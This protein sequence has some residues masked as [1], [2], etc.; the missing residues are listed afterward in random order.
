MMDEKP[1]RGPQR[2][3]GSKTETLA[4]R[5]AVG[6][7]RASELAP[8]ALKTA[9]AKRGFAE[10][11][12]LMEWRDVV[13]EA[14]ASVCRPVKVSYGG[15]GGPGLGA[16]LV[17]TTEGARAPEVE[18]QKTRIIEKVNVFYGYRAISRL[19]I[20]QSRSAT[21]P[22]PSTARQTGF[23]EAAE[24]WTGADESTQIREKPVS[25]VEDERLG[26]ALSRLGTNI[27]AR[28]RAKVAAERAASTVSTG[29]SHE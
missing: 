27:R 17:V 20:D 14:L 2:K 13:G 23:A 21:P 8:N 12:L 25:G 10:L 3:G 16:S 26:L 5:R 1:K 24:P 28:Q 22:L 7:L 4:L 29:E 9:G 15:R 18:M 6:F 19:V 11:R